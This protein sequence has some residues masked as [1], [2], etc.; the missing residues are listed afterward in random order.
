MGM[1]VEISGGLEMRI[2]GEG[3]EWERDE[4]CESEGGW[5]VDVG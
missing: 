3:R 5:G 4:G 2:R 1:E